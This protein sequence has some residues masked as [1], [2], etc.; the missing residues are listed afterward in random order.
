MAFAMKIHLQDTSREIV[1]ACDSELL[2]KTL[3][4]KEK[5]I[6]IKIE[7]SFYGEEEFEWPE[8][9]EKIRN[10]LNVNLFGNEIVDKAVK[11]GIIKEGG[12]IKVAGVKHAQI[13]HF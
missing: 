11:E 4:D 2:D 7:K 9:A 8:I 13:Y 5:E 10:G 3:T 1:A 12:V 6:E